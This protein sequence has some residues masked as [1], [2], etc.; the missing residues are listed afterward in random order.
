MKNLLFGLIMLASTASFASTNENFEA[1]TTTSEMTSIFSET[2]SEVKTSTVSDNDKWYMVTKITTH[3]YFI[4]GYWV[5]SSVETET[6]IE[7]R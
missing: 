7:W 4:L 5:G 6:T 1:K 2:T 3:N